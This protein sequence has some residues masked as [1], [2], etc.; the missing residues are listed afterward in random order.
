MLQETRWRTESRRL[1]ARGR[2]FKGP[3]GEWIERT[4]YEDDAGNNLGETTLT[5][6]RKR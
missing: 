3:Q 6:Q 5:F 4:R 2:I 1:T